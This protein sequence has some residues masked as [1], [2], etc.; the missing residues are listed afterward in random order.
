MAAMCSTTEI[1]AFLYVQRRIHMLC[2]DLCLSSLWTES[3]H[4]AHSATG[5]MK[6]Q[7]SSH[8]G[9]NHVSALFL[10]ASEVG[11]MLT[12]QGT[13][14]WWKLNFS[15][16][17]W[18]TSQHTGTFPLAGPCY[19]EKYEGMAWWQEMMR[20]WHRMG[21]IILIYPFWCYI[22]TIFPTSQLND[23]GMW[24]NVCDF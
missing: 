8:S 3:R 21:D 12:I 22:Q 13:H 2:K 20:K 23:E 6:G 18:H 15:P 7:S 9:W 16:T 24:L 17:P 11:F 14:R 1:R 19:Q 10:H 4:A 5:M